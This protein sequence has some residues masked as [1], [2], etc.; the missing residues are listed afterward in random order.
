MKKPDSIPYR[1]GLA[2]T[3]DGH[4]LL[5]GK[6]RQT[7]SPQEQTIELWRIPAEGGEPQRLGLAMENL[8]DVTV[9]PDGRRIAFSAGKEG[10]EVWVLENFLPKPKGQAARLEE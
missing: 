2:W 7:D 5:F 4:H 6:P 9:H 3:P 8:R 1:R 10:A